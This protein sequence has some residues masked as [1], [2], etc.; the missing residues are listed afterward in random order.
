MNSNILVV[1]D[2]ELL[3]YTLERIF[4][5]KGYGVVL[6]GTF[7]EAMNIIDGHEPDLIFSDIC[8]KGEK[9]GIDILREVKKRNLN[10]PVVIFTGYADIATASEAVRLSAFDYLEKP[11]RKN[12]LLHVTQKAL[13]YKALCDENEKYRLNL[14]AIFRCAGD[15]IISVDKNF[16]V[17]AVN[18]M[19]KGI[20]P[21]FQKLFPGKSFA[22]K[23]GGCR[24]KCVEIL[25][26][27]IKKRNRVEL[28]N[29]RCDAG[30]SPERIITIISSPL[31]DRRGVFLGAVLVMRDET[32]LDYLETVLKERKK[33]HNI[34]GSEEAMQKIYSLIET[35]AGVTSTVLITGE[36]GTGKELVAEAIHYRGD[37]RDRSLVKVS[38]SALSESLLESELFGY[39]RGAF[40]GALK[41]RR[42]R[43]ETADGG[44]LFLDEIGDINPSVQLKLLRFLQER[45]F[46]R[47]GDNRTIKVDVRII[48]ATNQDL[49]EKVRKGSFRE[50]LYYRLKV[51]EINLPP[52]RKR[53]KDI[54]LLTEHFLKKF[55]QK[56]NKNIFSLSPHI[57][58]LFMDYPWPGN[59]RELKHTIEHAFV[60]CETNTIGL[61][62]LP[63]EFRTQKKHLP[64][65]IDKENEAS[66]IR[67]V[68]E[69]TDWNKAKAARTL[70]IT[71]PTLYKK[72]Q[73]YGISNG[74]D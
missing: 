25:K 38:C 44:T 63:V 36:S 45:E 39:V 10:C 24:G 40:T 46:E 59:V 74:H 15:G 2:D 64:I 58:K 8:L 47:L 48:A 49:R 61:E 7:R 69:K 68:L 4:S 17:L 3:I 70:G 11:V 28:Y 35:L 53:K 21:A 43:F 50:D 22:K 66:L 42:G 16:K 31:T 14:E 33:F 67:E 26:E 72:M 32:R 52:L 30:P 5:E 54:P 9:T 57:L 55:Q 65:K 19:V 12:K 13:N 6:A 41:D 34:I 23:T 1:E 73:I 56:F 71:R 29:F 20:C 60:L 51:I 18:D 37:R 27:T 62:D